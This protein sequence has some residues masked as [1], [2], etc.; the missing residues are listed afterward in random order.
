M[1][2]LARAAPFEQVVGEELDIGPHPL[3]R[4]R[5]RLPQSG[6]QRRWWR[7]CGEKKAED[8][9]QQQRL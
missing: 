3:R 9:E 2:A 8:G 4:C 1:P 5:R 7:R 6:W